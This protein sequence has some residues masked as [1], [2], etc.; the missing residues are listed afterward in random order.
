M[1]LGREWKL[2]AL[3]EGEVYLYENM[4]RMVQAN[5]GDIIYLQFQIGESFLGR[6]WFVGVLNKFNMSD[7]QGTQWPLAACTS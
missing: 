1:N 6:N 3:A 7:T 2:G 5:K 4:A